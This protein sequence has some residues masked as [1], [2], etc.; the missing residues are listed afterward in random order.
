MSVAN[1]AIECVPCGIH[2]ETI[3]SKEEHVREKHMKANKKPG[4]WKDR[5]RTWADAM[6]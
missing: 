3:E 1:P 5:V 2:F 4:N 6:L